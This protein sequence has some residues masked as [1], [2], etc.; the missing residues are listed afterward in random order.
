MSSTD[1]QN[2]RS[3]QFA[4]YG[5]PDVLT[6]VDVPVPRPGPNQVRIAVRRAGVNPMDWKLRKGGMAQQMPL[7]LPHVPGLEVAGVVDAVGDGADFA[8]GDEVFGWS[9]TGSYAEYALAAATDVIRKPASLSWEDAVALPVAGE[10]SLRV[11]GLLDL[12]TGETLLIHGASGAVGAVATQIAATRGVNV[13][14]TSGKDNLDHL[15]ALGAT[16][17]VYGDGLVDRVRE[18]APNGVDAVFDAAGYGSLPDS[19]ALRGD[20]TDRI[21]TIADPAA[22]DMGI[23]FSGTPSADKAGVLHELADLVVAG[24]L[25]ITQ[26]RGYT[27]AEAAEA[28]RDSESGHSGGKITLRVE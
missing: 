28:H 15:R 12:R 17:V 26:G 1:T 23:T 19:V 10:T 3:V 18:I 6:V 22:F 24:P 16:P 14:G 21:V 25:K 27:L 9:E 2:M 7:D 11:L 20:T 5:E 4:E 8:V 13:I